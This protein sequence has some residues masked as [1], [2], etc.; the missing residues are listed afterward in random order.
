MRLELLLTFSVLN[1][2]FGFKMEFS[3]FEFARLYILTY[4]IGES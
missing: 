3:S 1:G 2:N 4:L